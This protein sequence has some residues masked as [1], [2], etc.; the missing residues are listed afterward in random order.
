MVSAFLLKRPQGLRFFFNIDAH[1]GPGQPNKE[2]DVQLVQ[3]AYFAKSQTGN[4]PLLEK[5]VYAKVVPGAAY[6]GEVN[7]PLSNAIR[8]HQRMRGGTQDTRVSPITG[9]GIYLGSDG[10]HVF[11]LVALVNNI[12]DLIKGD[13]PRIDKHG[14]CPPALKAAVSAASTL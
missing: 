4:D 5:Q 13:Y 7:D 2:A 6:R 9:N 12:F 3:F 10:G 14:K 1:V 8:L 11:M